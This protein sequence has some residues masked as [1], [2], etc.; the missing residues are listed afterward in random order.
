MQGLK[1]LALEPHHPAYLFSRGLIY[2]APDDVD[3]FIYFSR[4][5]LE[6]L[7]K[8]GKTP[9]IIHVHDW[10]TSLIPVLYKEMYVPLGLKLKG[11]VLTIHNL[12]HQGK[13]SPQNVTRAV[14][15][16]E[17]FLTPEKMQDPFLPGHLNL[18]KGGIEYADFITTVSPT[19]EK[20]IQTVEGGCGLHSV[21]AQYNNKLKGILN[22]IDYD[23]W[24]PETDPH[25]PLKYNITTA[26]KGKQESK[27][28]LRKK[29]GLK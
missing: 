14:L 3:R 4:A 1:I 23:Y 24:N 19:Y 6:Y 16:G 20:E 18:L 17:D 10:P 2:G 22:G 15:R 27:A 21:L 25:L 7:Y 11:T 5:A 8:S 26:L 28:A 12:Q 9:D 13:C 29:L